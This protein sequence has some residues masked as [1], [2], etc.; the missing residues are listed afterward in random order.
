MAWKRREILIKR[1]HT[2]LGSFL[3]GVE[4]H[5]QIRNIPWVLY[6]YIVRVFARFLAKI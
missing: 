4:I 5:Y 1:N 6:K 2:K 3:T